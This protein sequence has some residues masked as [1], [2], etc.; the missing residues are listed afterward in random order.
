MGDED[1]SALSDIEIIQK[2][3]THFYDQIQQQKLLAL[4]HQAESQT[5]QPADISHLK[6]DPTYEAANTDFQFAEK[7][8]QT[9]MFVTF[10]EEKLQ[11][12]GE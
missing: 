3:I 7:F 8:A 9:Q 6:Q 5:G 10:V 12:V 2:Q 1:P 11:S 4:K